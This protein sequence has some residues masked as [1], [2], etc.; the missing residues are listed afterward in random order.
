M[1][2]VWKGFFLDAHKRWEPIA[3][4]GE[5]QICGSGGRGEQRPLVQRDSP[6]LGEEGGY[7]R[8]EERGTTVWGRRRQSLA[9]EWN[10]GSRVL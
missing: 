8:S 9:G 7:G 6:Q 1:R 4:K 5:E 3:E 2:A 10:V